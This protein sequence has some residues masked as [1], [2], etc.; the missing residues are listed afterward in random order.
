[1]KSQDM[2]QKRLDLSAVRERLASLKGREYWRSLEQLAET[3][4][5]KEFL[6]REFPQGASEWHEAMSRRNFLKLMG[7]SL[8]LAGLTGCAGQPEEIILPYVEAPEN[9]VPGKPLFFATAMQVGGLATGLLVENHMGRPTKV[10]GN[11][12]HPASLGATDPFAQAS[13]LSL[14]DPD[15]AK[16]AMR[17]ATRISSW[18]AFGQAF[19]AELE[20]FQANG[21]TGLRIL[22]ETIT[23]STLASQMAA[24]LEM[25]PNARWHQYEPVSRDT[26][27]Q[28]ALL[29]FGEDV[30]AQYNIEEARVILAIDDDFLASGP[31]YLRYARRFVERRREGLA[32]A[33]L[34]RLYVVETMPTPTGT[35]ADHRLALRAGQMESFARALARELG[36]EVEAGGE[37][38]AEWVA[39]VARDLQNNRGA[40][41]VTAGAYQPPAVHAL[42]HAM[43]ETLGN[44]G[45]T[46]IYTDPVATEPVDQT[47]SLVELA[48]D[49]QAGDVQ[50]LVILGVNPVYSAPADLNFAEALLNVPNRIYW[51]MYEDET[52][53]L[54]TWFIPAAHY[55]E[56]WSDARAFDGTVSIVQPLTRPLYPGCVTAHE[57]LDLMTGQGGRTPY[58]IVRE[59]WQNQNLG[60]D[61]EEVWQTALHE[62][63]ISDTSLPARQVSLQSDFAANLPPA[64]GAEAGLELVFR[65]DPSVWDGRFANNGWLQE[66]PKPLLKLTWDNAALMSLATAERLGL[67][68]FDVV[69]LIYR[70]RSINAPVLIVP[71]H[72]NDSVTV[73]LGY[74]RQRVGSVGE[75]LGFSAYALRTSDAA[76]FG[77]GLEVRPTGE[78]Y[79]LALTQDHHTMEG[80]NLVRAAPLAQFQEDPEFAQHMSHEPAEGHPSLYPEYTYDSYAWGMVVDLGSCTG[81]NACVVACQAENN[82]PIVGKEGVLR[83]REMHWLRIDTYYAGEDVDN[84]QVYNQPMMCQH[85]EKAPCEVVCPVAATVHS[86]EG[87]N[88]MVYNRCVGTRY[89]SNNCP[90]KVRRFNFFQYNDPDIPVLQLMHNPDVTVRPRGVME[91]CTYCVQRI[92][93]ARIE[94]K[95]E[96]RAIRDGEVVTACQAA[97]PTQAIIFGD[98]NDPESQVSRFKSNP[99]NYGV[100][101]ELNTQPRTSYLAIVKNPNPEINEVA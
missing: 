62:G 24:V 38:P 49:M 86:A 65:P 13:I 23:S 40:S 81:C 30:Q 28:G 22:T 66:L 52:S 1:M 15:R 54:S 73:Y 9:L 55:L 10:E 71:G 64:A 84:P 96:N 68:N 88:E 26:A 89:C 74:G 39:A 59:Y 17:L 53:W 34:N 79:P 100:L 94:A 91:K 63:L 27:R 80:R 12:S 35:M 32:A 48:A 6:H 93:A 47:G 58:E 83:A 19:A 37:V 92:N 44:V 77:N 76:W 2:E 87:L 45:N 101:T 82:I 5:F 85:C 97:C 16:V 61:F 57:V 20:Q 43:N 36:L 4:T 25:Y 56:A 98:I 31:G 41:L 46:V 3:D 50:T 18:Q 60:G 95:K 99:L 21:G 67:T 14:Y 42:V 33:E 90:Y 8:A 78:R 11:P 7:A 70:E 51:G 72:A 29:A 75:G 69:E